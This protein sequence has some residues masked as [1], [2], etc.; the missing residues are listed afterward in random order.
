MAQ[1]ACMD[2][3]HQH[4]LMCHVSCVWRWHAWAWAW[5]CMGSRSRLRVFEETAHEATSRDFLCTRYHCNWGRAGAP[6][7]MCHQSIIIAAALTCVWAHEAA[8]LTCAPTCAVGR[9][10]AGA[11]WCQAGLF[12][13]GQW[14]V[15]HDWGC[16]RV[17]N[18]PVW[19]WR[20]TTRRLHQAYKSQFRG[21]TRE[22]YLWCLLC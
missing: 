11:A 17:T 16:W 14:C 21:H 10:P 6:G 22:G 3:Q 20:P 4:A 19:W 5:N 7:Y 2:G 8:A 18:N 1:V 12:S 13:W 9:C 15:T